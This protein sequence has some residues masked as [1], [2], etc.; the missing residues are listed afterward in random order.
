MASRFLRSSRVRLVLA[1][2]AFPCIASE[3]FRL[4]VEAPRPARYYLR[5]SAGKLWAPEGAITYSRRDEEHFLARGGFEIR[6]PPGNYTLQVERGPEHI[7][8]GE[9]IVAREGEEKSLRL[10]PRRWIG[11]NRLGWYSGD[12]HNHRRLEHMPLL[13]L[14]EDLN[15]A[16]TLTDWIWEDRQ[17]S[18]PPATGAAIQRV[19]ATHV[20]SVVDKEVERLKSGPGAVDLVGLRAP[21]PFDG[22]LLYPPND[23]FAAAAHAQGAW[24]D[25]EKIVWRD[26]AALVAL[27]H[28]DFAGIVHNHFNR[29]GVETE[30]DAWGM[31]PKRQPEYRTPA[32][33]PLWAMEIYYRFLNCGFR[34]PVSAGSASG[35]KASPLGYNRVYVKTGGDFSYENWFRALKAG[36]S[37]ATNGPMLFLSVNGKEPGETLRFD[38]GRLRRVRVKA[39]ASSVTPLDRLEILSKGKV[40]RTASGS[41]KLR[42]DFEVEAGE[43]GWIAA[44][45]FEKPDRTV[46]FAH[47]SPVYIEVA[48]DRGIVVE[49]ASF[50]LEWIDREAAFYRDL[51]GFRDPAHRAA[52]LAFFDSARK[53]YAKLAGG[54]RQFPSEGGATPWRSEA[55]RLPTAGPA[56]KLG[57]SPSPNSHPVR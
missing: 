39:E 44:R 38:S 36:R 48:G 41:G 55:H 15:I 9:S 24:V 16:P 2:A 49:D 50:F 4:R 43:T 10:S 12:L 1:A 11:M 35:V 31:V 22:Y 47:T 18:S 57:G 5:D 7:P 19:D 42:L 28:I 21:I 54:L 45:A 3:S 56:T 23:R 32:G 27:G 51:P 29:Q 30:T 13:L 34:L 37:F 20:Y 46:R 14:A 40:I 25:A 8:V 33:M 17:N 52:M 26:V 6:L 53:V